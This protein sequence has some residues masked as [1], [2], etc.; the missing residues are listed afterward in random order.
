MPTIVKTA[1]RKVS[2]MKFVQV[3]KSFALAAALVGAQVAL[4]QDVTGAGAQLFQKGLGKIASA[5]AARDM[6]AREARQLARRETR[7]ALRRL[8]TDPRTAKAWA[9]ATAAERE[10]V[11]Y[12]TH[13]E[14]QRSYFKGYLEAA[15]RAKAQAQAALR[16]A[17]QAA[18]ARQQLAAAELAE[19]AATAAPVAG[20]LP[21]NHQFAGKELP[22]E[23]LPPA[24]RKQG[25]RFTETGF[26]DFEPFARPLPN[27]QKYVEIRYTGSLES[28]FM[29]ANAKAGFAK[30]PRGYTWHHSEE[31]GKMYLVPLELHRAVGH[32]GGVARYKHVTGDII[33]YVK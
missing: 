23:L 10:Q 25:L 33:S 29:A 20:R 16:K 19:E 30:T 11:M 17:P 7:A 14:L 13:W 4:A 1:L 21:R 2:Q 28:D 18:A 26:P 15:R 9:R 24:Y 6:I 8:A 32:T 31:L 22:R 27:G 3:S 12:I 5:A